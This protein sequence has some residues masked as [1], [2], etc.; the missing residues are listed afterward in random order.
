MRH[1]SNRRY[2][3]RGTTDWGPPRSRATVAGQCRDAVCV[4]VRSAAFG[5]EPAS[6]RSTS[7]LA[8]IVSRA[9]W[10]PSRLG[11]ALP[12]RDPYLGI[13][14]SKAA[15]R[16][17]A[18]DPSSALRGMKASGA[19]RRAMRVSLAVSDDNYA[20]REPGSAGR[21]R[22]GL[23]RPHLGRSGAA[24]AQRAALQREDRDPDRVADA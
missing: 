1:S 17:Q 20:C 7:R 3:V 16:C 19:E 14:P 11:L 13:G 18:R 23:S 4:R 15:A 24:D 10:Q 8:P 2:P 6:S 5:P 9:P 12:G 21:P 22:V